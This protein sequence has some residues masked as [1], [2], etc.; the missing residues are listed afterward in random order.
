MLTANVNI[1]WHKRNLVR[2]QI[3]TQIL[4]PFYV[5]RLKQYNKT[6]FGCRSSRCPGLRVL[7][8]TA[9]AH[10]RTNKRAP[11]SSMK[12]VSFYPLI[13]QPIFWLNQHRK[14]K[15]SVADTQSRPD[16]LS[17]GASSR[18]K[19]PVEEFSSIWI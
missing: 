8:P 10:G 4:T 13:R 16:L 3:L 1:S 17:S 5:C 9:T 15:L 14:P 7:P 6:S 18:T 2:N 12:R 11:R 19:W